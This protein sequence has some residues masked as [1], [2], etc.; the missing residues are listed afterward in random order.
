MKRIALIGAIILAAAPATAASAGAATRP[1][2]AGLPVGAGPAP[3]SLLDSFA[4]TP[5]PVPTDR[6]VSIRAVMRPVAGTER[7]EMRIE[8]L[9][10]PRA[11]TPFGDVPGAAN[12]WIS[13][14][15]PTLGQRPGDVWI[16][17][18]QVRNLPAPFAYRYRVTFR[19]TGTQGRVLSTRMR[20]SAVCHQ[21]V[22]H[23]DLFVSSIT[24][25]PIVG[26]PHKDQYVAVIANQGVGP[27][28]AGFAVT[29]TPAAS[30]TPGVPPAT[31]T[32]F[33][34][35]LGIGATSQV[36]FVGPACTATTAP[37]VV[38]DPG[39][40]VD[41]SNFANNSLTVGPT[42]PPVTAAPPSVP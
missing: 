21:P 19:W 15:D 17:P 23:P 30:L 2:T 29:F 28:P 34:P 5:A 3:R 10:R 27:T 14:T 40:T 32:K 26:K 20:M 6:S 42:C 18:E 4:C 22:F 1:A 12:A 36:A 16:V 11:G 39:H 33:L 35:S 31:T 41:E 7:M 37:T 24:V 38:V 9:S 13:P 25:Q 8:L